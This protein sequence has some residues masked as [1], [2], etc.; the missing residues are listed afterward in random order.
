LRHTILD[1]SIY[2]PGQCPARYHTGSALPHVAGDAIALFFIIHYKALA[3]RQRRVNAG[4]WAKR[5]YVVPDTVD[6]IGNALLVRVLKAAH[7]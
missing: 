2:F 5:R 7:H 1:N 4:C 6:G 3:A